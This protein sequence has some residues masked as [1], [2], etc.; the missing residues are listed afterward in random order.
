M[1]KREYDYG[2]HTGMKSRIKRIYD[3][4]TQVADAK[5]ACILIVIFFIVSLLPIVYVGLHNYP[6]GDDY[7][8]G[9]YTNRAW[10]ETGSIWEALKGSW[11]MVVRIYTEWQGTWFTLFLFT[12][13][14]NIFIEHGYYLTVFIGLGLLTGSL[15]Y[16]LHFY[17]VRKLQFRK[18]VFIIILCLI[19]YPSIQ[20]IPRTTS[21]IFWF[22]GIMHYS[23][24]LLL[25][26]VAV[27][28][29]QKFVEGGGVKNYLALF[30][31]FIL[32]GG[33]SYLMPIAAS[34]VVLLILLRQ[35]KVRKTE[36]RNKLNISF[37]KRNWL[38]FLALF[39]ECV[40]LLISFLAPGNSVRGGEEFGADINWAIKTVWYAIDRGIYLGIDYFENNMILVLIYTI[41]SVIVWGEMWKV[42]KNIRFRYPLLFVIYTNGIYWATYTPEIYARS[43]V[44]GGVHNTYFHVFL[45]VTL[46][47]MIYVHGWLQ[48]KIYDYWDKKAIQETMTN[49]IW[50][51]CRFKKIIEIPLLIF[52]FVVLFVAGNTTDLVTTNDYCVDYVVS[53]RMDEYVRI[54]EEQHRILLE[55][56]SEDVVIPEAGDQYPLLHMPLSEN[57]EAKP[58]VNMAA[59]Y[60][61]NSVSAV[62]A[63]E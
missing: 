37:A 55:E 61:K 51:G 6:S 24:P 60:G 7:W 25:A 1:V 17:L 12:L 23:V 3:N 16:L 32:L 21:G 39:M 34:L 47:N 40:G 29:T 30:I 9:V 58:N 20:Y 53:G 27:V 57:V 38:I 41:L 2:R 19:L 13:S 42:S 45:L 18:E 14:P 43:D 59:F 31:S 11:R 33:G 44:S 35:I 15:G 10:V 5:K 46:A 22:N 26:C 28:N 62:H 52:L 50:Y 4:I 54:R 8:F 56:D 63:E 49:S 36:G 48:N